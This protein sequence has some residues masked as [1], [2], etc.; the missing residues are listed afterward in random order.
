MGP[1]SSAGNGGLLAEGDASAA[2]GVFAG[3]QSSVGNQ[4]GGG[5]GGF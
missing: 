5:F 4:M 2:P 3:E 1:V